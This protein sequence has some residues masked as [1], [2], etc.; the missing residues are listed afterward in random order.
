MRCFEGPPSAPGRFL[1]T[2]DVPPGTAGIIRRW[3]CPLYALDAVGAVYGS[4]RLGWPASY[5]L[6]KWMANETTRITAW[7]WGRVF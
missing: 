7:V 6:S 5:P 3:E 4:T 1:L 2:N